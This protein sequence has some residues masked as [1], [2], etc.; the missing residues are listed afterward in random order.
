MH[1][2]M[3]KHTGELPIIGVN[4]FRNPRSGCGLDFGAQHRGEEK[5]NQLELR[6]TAAIT[7]AG[8]QCCGGFNRR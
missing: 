2:E 6:T 7:R 1:Y 3:L 5:L 4:T 8:Q